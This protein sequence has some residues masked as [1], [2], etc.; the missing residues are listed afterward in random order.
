MSFGMKI[1]DYKE[2]L[3][4]DLKA[5]AEIPSVSANDKQSAEA[6]LNFV[7]SRAAEMGFETKK[8]SPIC[9]HIQYGSGE[10]LC[11]VLAHVDVVPAGEGWSVEPYSLTEKDGRYLGRGVVDDKGPAITALYCL[12]ALK[13]NGIEPDGRIRLI[14][15]AAEEIGMDD[16]EQYFVSEEMPEMAFTP[17]S[18][19]GICLK[20]KGILH[21]EITSPYHDGTTLTEFH[22]GNAINAVPSKAYALIDCTE[23]EDH[24]LRR[25]A[26]AKPG[27]YDFIYTMDGL[28]IDGTGTAAH[29]S[30]PEKGLNIAT[31]LIRILAADFGQTVLGSL[32]GFLD[33]AIGLETD[34][35]SLGIACSDVL[36]GA[37]TVNL[38][39]VDIDDNVSRA[40]L[41]IRYPVTADS[42]EICN[43]IRE[44]AS[45]DGLR[46]RVIGHELPLNMDADAHVIQI[47]KKAYK[48]FTGEEAELYSTGGGTYARTLKN[49]G[50]A[51]GPAFPGDETHIHDVDEGISVE[52][53]WK[54]AGICLE[55]MKGMAE[56]L[57][58]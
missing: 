22:A 1:Y 7:L 35:M 39:R 49:H 24:Q 55:A 15:G 5:L 28:R 23:T 47:L 3:L 52:N 45:Y 6:A 29:A 50:V 42:S 51:F 33:D 4:S 31:H 17:D 32:C 10:K 43:K 41:D 14:L 21:I 58:N 27:Q 9:A 57:N 38:G 2:E 36:S 40:Y 18:D 46:A 44:R 11:A 30:T 26:D 56:A 54:H 12:K 48:D 53:F 37:L 19:Y 16:M 20:E 34:G 8:V 25:F 13:D